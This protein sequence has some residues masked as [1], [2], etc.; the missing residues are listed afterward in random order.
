MTQ[1]AVDDTLMRDARAVTTLTSD[2]E[3]MEEALRCF[4]VQMK[5]QLDALQYYGKL[6][7]DGDWIGEEDAAGEGIT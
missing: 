6:H 2:K 4:I 7:W 1:V 3:I 5:N